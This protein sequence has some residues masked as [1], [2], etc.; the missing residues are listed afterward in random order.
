MAVIF[1]LEECLTLADEVSN[2]IKE[3][4]LGGNANSTTFRKRTVSSNDVDNLDAEKHVGIREWDPLLA[5]QNYLVNE[6]SVS[7]PSWLSSCLFATYSNMDY[8]LLMNEQRIVVLSRFEIFSMTVGLD[9]FGE[10]FYKV[11]GYVMS[12]YITCGCLFGLG[13]R[14]VSET[15]DCMLVAVGLSNGYVAF[16]TERGTLLFYERFCV[17][18]ITAVVFDHFPDTQQLMVVTEVDFFSVNPVMLHSTLLQAKVSIAKGEKSAKELSETLEIECLRLEPEQRVKIRNTVFTGVHKQTCFEQYVTASLTSFHQRDFRPDLPKYSTYLFTS[19]RMFTTFIWHSEAESDKIW[20]EAIKIG[21]S[22]VPHFGIRQFLGLSP[23]NQRKSAL[24]LSRRVAVS[25]GVLGDSRTAEFISR[26]PRPLIAIVDH[27]ARVILIDTVHRQIIRIWKGYRGASVSWLTSSHEGRTALY[28]AI[29]APRRAL[30]EVWNVQSGVRVGAQHVDPGGMLVEGGAASIL[31][32]C[33]DGRQQTDSF[34][35]DANLSLNIM[36]PSILLEVFSTLRTQKARKQFL[37]SLLPMVENT[38]EFKELLENIIKVSL[39]NSKN[40]SIVTG[41]NKSNS[42]LVFQIDSCDSLGDLPDMILNLLIIYNRIVD[43]HGQPKKQCDF[44]QLPFNERAVVIIQKH[45]EF[46]ESI[47]VDLLKPGKFFSIIDWQAPT[48]A[49]FDKNL[50]TIDLQHLAYLIF[51]PVLSG[52][53][54]LHTFIDSVIDPLPVSMEHLSSLLSFY[55]IKDHSSIGE[56]VFSRF[57][58]LIAYFESVHNGAVDSYERAAIESTNLNRALLMFSACCIVKQRCDDWETFDPRCEYADCTLMTMHAAWLVAQLQGTAAYSQLLTGGGGFFREQVA[59]WVA[60]LEFTVDQ[61]DEYIKDHESL[62]ELCS[63]LPLTLS[64][65]LLRCDVGWELMTHWFKEKTKRFEIIK[66]AFSYISKVNDARLKHGI[67]R[68]VWDNFLAEPF[69]VLV[70]LIEKIGRGPK[71]SEARQILQVP[72]QR[73]EISIF[74]SYGT[75]YVSFHIEFLTECQ[76]ILI[77]LMDAVRDSPPP[78]SVP[79]DHLLEVA[80]SHPP[81]AAMHGSAS[82]DSLVEI[83][84]RQQL[85]NY[86]LVLHHVHLCM[87]LRLQLSVGLRLQPLRI[88]FCSIGQRAFFQQLDSHPLIPLDRVD[89][90]VL[91]KRHQFITKISEQGTDNDRKLAR[92][93]AYQWNLTVDSIAV[94]QIIC[95]LRMGD[96]TNASRELANVTP[97]E[98]LIRA[99]VR[100]LAARVIR[101]VEEENVVIT[102]AH[103]NYLSDIAGDE[104][105][106]VEWE[107]STWREAVL[108]LGWMIAALPPEYHHYFMRIGGILLQYFGLQIVD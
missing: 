17:D 96:D 45:L 42:K 76:N 83:A 8:V 72:E 57:I 14:R 59:V 47:E 12:D 50:S 18:A 94:M 63:L 11:L 108:S 35:I 32:R 5:Q 46:G 52:S 106:R 75:Y 69:R 33:Q 67:A 41:K 78:V 4:L 31:C 74:L 26:A 81:T 77:M 51:S 71:E 37:L 22:I 107:G 88:L 27:A 91:E 61:L 68:M 9:V 98:K 64:P 92:D 7:P 102:I 73:L 90:S 97:T 48:T 70:Q 99:I 101:L 21:K 49:I 6:E 19:D 80:L 13:S 36:N 105:L 38:E 100:L 86:H 84:S 40:T 56:T 20:S 25:R 79:V 54:D 55:F 103:S 23:A 3:Y 53:V 89:D 62:S 15:L 93:L 10:I 104:S 65:T 28:L 66:L 2:R 58:D 60:E 44:G 82:R 30:L 1:Q 95:F 29:Y 34:F 39:G 43:Y 87:A 16:L 85:V 24:S